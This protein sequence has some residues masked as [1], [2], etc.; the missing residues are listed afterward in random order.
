M[1]RVPKK[2][3]PV[4]FSAGFGFMARQFDPDSSMNTLDPISIV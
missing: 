4:K 3:F 1:T 2:T